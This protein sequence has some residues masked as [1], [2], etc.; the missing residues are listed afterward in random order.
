[1]LFLIPPSEGKQSWWKSN[2]QATTF[3]YDLPYSIAQ[4]ATEKDLKCT[5]KRYQEAM[6]LNNQIQDSPLLPAIERYTWVMFNAINYPDMH[7]T[8]QQLFNRHVCIISWLY[9]LLKPQ[10]YIANYKLPISSKW[11]YQFRWSTISD[12]LQQQQTELIIDLLPQA[13]K[14]VIQRDQLDATVVTVDFKHYWKRLTHGVKSVKWKR[15]QHIC[16]DQLLSPQDRPTTI[17]TKDKDIVVSCV[18]R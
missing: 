4:H 10:D 2:L 8:A 13:H 11:L 16:A 6:E 5:G 12:L 15:L 7:T 17:Q 18:V 3:S 1:M 14:K 9:G